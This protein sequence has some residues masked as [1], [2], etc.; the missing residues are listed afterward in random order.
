MRTVA[1]Q[2]RQNE[3]W[4]IYV[5]FFWGYIIQMHHCQKSDFLQH[6]CWMCLC[7]LDCPSNV[8][9]QKSASKGRVDGYA[10]IKINTCTKSH[11]WHVT[12]RG[13]W[14][15]CCPQGFHHL[16]PRSD[17]RTSCRTKCVCAD[18]V[19]VI[20]QWQQCKMGVRALEWGHSCFKMEPLL[21]LF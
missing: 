20:R 18:F 11:V 1:A 9:H 6:S 21:C 7:R 4:S 10:S 5:F 14:R 12:V 2:Y 17:Y 16:S 19:V 8:I 13:N 15:L 3:N